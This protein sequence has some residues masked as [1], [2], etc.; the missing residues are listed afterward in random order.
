M[1]TACATECISWLWSIIKSKHAEY[2][3]P[4]IE[5]VSTVP[6]VPSVP[7]AATSLV[8]SRCSMF[9]ISEPECYIFRHCPRGHQWSTAND[10]PRETVHS[11]A[12]VPLSVYRSS[13]RRVH[14]D[15]ESGSASISPT[16]RAMGPV[17]TDS[18][19]QFESGFLLSDRLICAPICSSHSQ[20]MHWVQGTRWMQSSERSQ[21]CQRIL[22]FELGSVVAIWMRI[23]LSVVTRDQ[24]PSMDP[25]QC[26]DQSHS[27]NERIK[28][29]CFC[30]EF[31]RKLFELPHIIDILQFAP[32]SRRRELCYLFLS[33]HILLLLRFCHFVVIFSSSTITLNSVHQCVSGRIPITYLSLWLSMAYCIL[34]WV[35]GV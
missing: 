15:S 18:S 23:N 1:A 30:F 12:G 8:Q 27:M 20:W 5:M 35:S 14:G 19:E 3:R 10:G 31:W 22:P 9:P 11:A 6:S 29:R 26:V 16:H 32:C 4:T 24:C 25:M 21:R 28:Y 33:V 7:T 13:N 2:P 34:L 17:H